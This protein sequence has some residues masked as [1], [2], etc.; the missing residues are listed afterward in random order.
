[1]KIFSGFLF[2]N[3]R[4]A[5]PKNFKKLKTLIVLIMQP[6]EAREK[7]IIVHFNND[8]MVLFYGHTNVAGRQFSN[9]FPVRI[10]VDLA[11][12]GIRPEGG[13]PAVFMSSEHLFMFRKA[14]LFGDLDAAERI[15]TAPTPLSAK[16]LG[17]KVRGFDE[18]IWEQHRLNIMIE[19]LRLKFREPTLR[20]YLLDTQ[21]ATIVECS[22][23]D[24]IWGVGL[25]L[26]SLHCFQRDRWLGLNLLGTA[27]ETVR[28]EIMRDGQK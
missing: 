5:K 7:P 24:K 27:L 22:P 19:V 2:Y 8:P 14:I 6:N 12:Y 26:G 23:T 16:A 15:I 4:E 28:A 18:K 9:F 17:R 10:E 21:N 3:K 13:P 20:Q 25:K 1:L 11:Q